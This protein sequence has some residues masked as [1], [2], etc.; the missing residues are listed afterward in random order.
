MSYLFSKKYTEEQIRQ[1]ELERQVKCAYEAQ[2][3]GFIYKLVLIG[4]LVV[5]I[6]LITASLIFVRQQFPC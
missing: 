5:G 2:R 3:R 6:L 1:H 4:V